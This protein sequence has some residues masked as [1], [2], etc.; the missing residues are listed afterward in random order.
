MNVNDIKNHLRNFFRGGESEEGDRFIDL[1]YHYFDDRPDEL[2]ELDVNKKE[3][4]RVELLQE[5]RRAAG[6]PDKKLHRIGVGSSTSKRTWSY[7][8]A[9]GFA[10][11]LLA[12]IP[13]FLMTFQESVSESVEIITSSNPAGQSSKITLSD[14]ST[15]WL[16]ANSTLEYP[17]RFEGEYREVILH[18]EGFFDVVPNPDK[19]FI[20]KSGDLQTTVLGTS[21]NI[22][23]FEED[24]DI[25]ITVVT[26]RVSVGQTDAADD[27]DTPQSVAFLYPEQQLVY[28]NTTRESITQQVDS[29]IFSSWKE[30]L[31]MFENHTLEEIANRL[32][33][34]YG[35]EIQF[36]DPDLKKTRF[37][38]MF[39]N[40]SLEHALKMLQAI[41]D[42]E[43]KI[44]DRQIWIQ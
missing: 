4:L 20:V 40:T 34:W 18:G 24:K 10:V 33:R 15:I 2:S 6:I 36:T 11:L 37:R 13:V 23:A 28:N 14:G 17:E 41:K 31:L 35:V 19:P 42:F 29:R 21:F 44:E 30:G 38:I 26:G 1:W 8:M 39:E 22:R 9:A 5:I 25:Q 3:N 32:E 43:F 7:R 16:S 12:L 27:A